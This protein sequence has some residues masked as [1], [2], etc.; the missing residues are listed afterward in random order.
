MESKLSEEERSTYRGGV[1]VHG[2]ILRTVMDNA[3]KKT[4]DSTRSM[5]KEHSFK[6]KFKP[7]GII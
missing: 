5:S 3:I 2:I 4:A 6:K 1:L 7:M